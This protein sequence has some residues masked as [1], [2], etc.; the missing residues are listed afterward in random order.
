MGLDTWFR[1]DIANILRAGNEA[2]LSAIMAGEEA[3]IAGGTGGA[4]TELRSGFRRGFVAAL[5]TLSRALGLPITDID[6][7]FVVAASDWRQESGYHSPELPVR[8]PGGRR[9]VE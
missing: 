1:D 6:K 9:C 8:L 7:E 3:S 4:A 5:V 2:N